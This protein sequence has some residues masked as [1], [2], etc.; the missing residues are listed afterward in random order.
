MKKL[1]IAIDLG[2]TKCAGAA[3]T[4]DGKIRHKI[5]DKIT[6]LKGKEVS[7]KIYAM[8]M[9]IKEKFEES[10]RVSGI[11]ISVPGISNQSEGT[12]WAPNIPGWEDYPLM[13]DL[14]D[15]L[16]SSM[17]VH[18][19]S[20]R[21]CSIS[22][23][24]WM[25]VAKGYKNA[26]F[27]A[28]GTGIGAGILIDGK[29]LRGQ[30]D[31]AGSIGWMVLDDKF[32]EGY[33]QFGCF[34]YNASGDGLARLS[35]DIHIQKKINTSMDLTG[36]RAEDIFRAYDREDPLALETIDTALDYWAKTVANLVSIFNPEI[37]IFGGGLFG[38][39]LKLLDQIYERSRKW[40]QP[41]AINQ[42]RLVGGQLGVDAQLM[43]AAKLVMD[44]QE[45][46]N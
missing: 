25:G 28:F 7:H 21:A 43:G 29:V 4:E 15:R 38:P 23:E 33:I 12:V 36:I 44:K 18:I 11:G 39:G 13:T 10:F 14:K 6:G 17:V 30:S 3:I 45:Q 31:I 46:S 2:G 16:G 34:E 32:P 26:I 8:I 19:D 24:A 22:G 35:R 9:K 41:V 1:Y 20:D 37:I 5:K 40:A 42:V 27:L